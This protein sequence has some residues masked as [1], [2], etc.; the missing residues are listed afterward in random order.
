MSRFGIFVRLS[1]SYNHRLQL[2]IFLRHFP[3]VSWTYSKPPSSDN[4]R[5]LQ[6]RLQCTQSCLTTPEYNPVWSS[7]MVSY[8]NK[9]KLNC[10]IKCGLSKY[11]HN[12]CTSLQIGSF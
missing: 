9:S 7:D 6:S 11:T 3:A 8:D 2:T 1:R 5:K 4:I 12:I 10:A